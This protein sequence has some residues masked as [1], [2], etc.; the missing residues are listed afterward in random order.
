VARLQGTAPRPTGGGGGGYLCCRHFSVVS[1]GGS[2]GGG[3]GGGGQQQEEEDEADARLRQ[4]LADVASRF[5]AVENA[6]AGASGGA[7]GVSEEVGNAAGRPE[8]VRSGGEK[9]VIQFTCTSAECVEALPAD[10]AA[11]RVTKVISKKSY[12]EGVV[13]VRCPGCENLHMIAD[14]LGWFGEER[15]VVELMRAKGEAVA[16]MLG[17]GTLDI[18]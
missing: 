6:V 17:D 9:L 16:T 15:N 4:V 12:E 14:N 13:L 10:E 8:G 7:G 3:G 2:S 18:Q 1:S 5:G 11:R